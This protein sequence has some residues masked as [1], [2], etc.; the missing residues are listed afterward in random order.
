[1][2]SNL[3][4]QRACKAF[5]FVIVTLLWTML[6]LSIRPT[7]IVL[8]G[9]GPGGVGDTQGTSSLRLWLRADKGVYTDEACSTVILKNA[10]VAC[11]ADQSGN[12]SHVLQFNAMWQPTYRDSRA[13]NGYKP[14]LEFITDTLTTT[15]G[16]QLFS[17]PDSG[18]TMMVVFDSD[19]VEA[20][21]QLLGYG[22]AHTTAENHNLELGYDMGSVGLHRGDDN[23]TLT[24]GQVITNHTY[25]I[26]STLVLTSGN[27][28][29]NIRIFKNGT[30]Q[31]LA[32]EGSGWLSATHYPVTSV[33]LD[34]GARRDGN[35]PNYPD[36][37]PG[38]FHMGD[39]A[40]MIAYTTTLNTAQRTI[41]ENYLNAKYNR[42]VI[43]NDKYSGPYVKD[44]VGIG[45]EADGIHTA[46]SSA[47]LILEDAGY[48]EKN[49]DYIFAGHSADT[50]STTAANLPTGIA[51]RWTREWY[52]AKVYPIGEQRHGDV[53]LK[54]DFSE[55]GIAGTPNGL[56]VL[57][58]RNR[59]W[60]T[61]EVLQTTSY[62]VGDQ[63]IFVTPA[64]LDNGYYTL[65]K[66]AFSD[67]TVEDSQQPAGPVY[68]FEDISGGASVVFTDSDQ[69]TGSVSLGFTFNF[70]DVDYEEVYIGTD[71][72]ITFIP[73]Q[74]DD[75]TL[76]TLPNAGD[77]NGIIAG[78]WGDLDPY[79]PPLGNG[80]VYARME[81]SAPERYFI[82]QYEQVEYEDNTS[83]PYSVTFQI[84]LFESSNIIE[85][86]Y[87]NIDIRYQPLV[88]IENQA[89]TQ[90]LQYYYSKSPFIERAVRFARSP[91]ILDK[92]VTD[93]TPRVGD[94]ITYTLV[95]RSNLT[96]TTHTAALSETLDNGLTYFETV[97]Y[98]PAQSGAVATFAGQTLRIHSL[99]IA[100]GQRIT[101][102]IPVMVENTVLPAT[103]LMNTS[104]ITSVE[105][106][107]YTENAL[108]IVA[109]TCW[110]RVAG[111]AKIYDNVQDAIEA[112]SADDIVQIAGYCLDVETRGSAALTLQQVAYLTKSLTLRGGYTPDFSGEADPDTN[113]TIL[114]ARDLG[115]VVY[116][117][118]S[119]PP[120]T[121][122]VEGLQLEGGNAG[123][124]G[125]VLNGG[126]GVYALTST[127]TLSRTYISRSSAQQGG[128]MYA[129]NSILTLT[130]NH[131]FSNTAS[132]EGGGVYIVNASAV[133]LTGNLIMT[134]TASEEGGGGRLL[135][136]RG[137]ILNENYI[138]DNAADL[139]GGIYLE[140][141]AI[142]AIEDAVENNY[143][144]TSGGG[145]YMKVVTATVQGITVT[146]NQ[147]ID[148]G[149]GFYLSNSHAVAIA[150]ARIALNTAL[151]YGGGVYL[152]QSDAG[153]SNT[154][155]LTNVAMR[156]GGVYFEDSDAHL[157]NN[158]I[159]ANT[160]T[161][162]DGGGVYVFSS[163]CTLMTN[164]LNSNVTPGYGGALYVTNSDGMIA[165]RNTIMFNTGY[166]GGGVAVMNSQATFTGNV[167]FSNTAS[168]QGG[169]IYVDK[170]APQ[171]I[172]ND[173]TLNAVSGTRSTTGGGGFYLRDTSA[174][175]TTN[176]IATNTV[177]IQGGGLFVFGTGGTPNLIS[178]TIRANT[179]GLRGGGVY[180]NASNAH[181]I[182]NTIAENIAEGTSTVW[183]LGGGVCIDGSNPQ[184]TG[185]QIRENI[186]GKR[187]G[188]IFTQN[189][190]AQITGN[191]IIGNSTLR[192]RG[193]GVYIYSGNPTLTDNLIKGNL[194]VDASY[195]EGGGIYVNNNNATIN[196]NTFKDNFANNNGGGMY[197]IYSNNHPPLN[198]NVFL[199][200]KATN[201]GGGIYLDRHNGTLRN[202]VVAG[203]SI[204]NGMGS[205]LYIA[206]AS[207]KLLHTT[208]AQNSGGDQTG[209]SIAEFGGTLSTVFLTNT[210]IADQPVGVFVNSG[211]TAHL[212]GT[213]WWQ[214]TQDT[215][216]MGHI[217]THTV[218]VYA[219]PDFIAP[220]AGDY[221]IGVNSFALDAG[222]DGGVTTDLDGESRPHF[223]GY[224]IG[225]D[226]YAGTC[227]VRLN[228]APLR[229]A[230]IQEAVD[231]ASAGDTVKVAGT[232]RGVESHAG[233]S[234][235]VYLNKSITIQGGYAL[236]NWD[237]PDPVVY[238]T[239]VDAA[240]QGRV[241]YI[242]GAVQ[243]TLAGMR[244]IGGDASAAGDTRGGGLYVTTAQVTLRAVEVMSNTAQDGG[245]LYVQGGAAQLVNTLIAHNDADQHGSGIYFQGATHDLKHLTLA[246]NT[247]SEGVYLAG[248]STARFTNT[249]LVSHTLGINVTAGSTADMVA[250]LWGSGDWANQT[251]WTAAGTFN[252]E[253]DI[254]ADPAFVAPDAGD[255]HI[256][257][258]SGARDRG[259]DAGVTTDID[260]EA[261]DLNPD[262][263]IDEYRTCWIRLND[264][265]IT[266]YADIQ[267]AIDASTAPDDVIKVAGYCAGVNQRPRQDIITSGTVTQ[268]I[269]L[270]K[271]LTIQ[272]GYTMTNW[273]TP[274]PRNYP[275]TIDAV[276]QGRVLYIT[277]NLAGDIR[278]TLMNLRLVNGE[279]TGL[280]GSGSGD[281]G[282]GLYS[283]SANPIISSCQVLSN[284]GDYG[285][286][287]YIV[288][289]G[290]Q[291]YNTII[292][293]NE[294]TQQGGAIQGESAALHFIYTTFANNTG[295][296]GLYL[297]TNSTALLTNTILAGHTVG[298]QTA[299]GSSAALDGVLWW[300]NGT[301]WSGSVTR[302]HERVGDPAF[303]SPASQDYHILARSAAID[304]V[305]NAAG[306]AADVDLEPRPV[307]DGYDLGADEFSV[308]VRVSKTAAPDPVLAGDTLMFTIMVTNT[309]NVAFDAVITDTLPDH[310]TPGGE[311]V[312]T[313]SIPA[314]GGVWSQS[315]NVTVSPSYVGPITNTGVVTTIVKG[316]A[317]ESTL[318]GPTRYFTRAVGVRLGADL[319]ISKVT[320]ADTATPGDWV[321]YTLTYENLGPSVV[322]DVIISDLVPVSLISVTYTSSGAI[323]TSTGGTSYT[324]AVAPLSPGNGGTITV[325]GT[326]DSGYAGGYAFTNTAHI[327]NTTEVGDP[328]ANNTSM[329]V[330]IIV[331]NVAPIAG[332][333]TAITDEDIPVIIP[334]RENDEDLNGDALSV[335]DVGS[336]ITG[337]T[338][339]N[340]ATITYIPAQDFFGTDIF[341]YTVSDGSL[342][343]VGA[344]TVTVNSVNDPP[345]GVSD[346]VT[347]DE[348]TPIV[349]DVLAND[350]DVD[351]DS[352]MIGSVGIPG[353]GNVT[354]DG[355]ML[356]YTPTL[357]FNGVDVF[358]YT[359][360][361]GVFAD[362]ATVMMTINAVNDAPV[363]HDDTANTP[364]NTPRTVVV[365][366][367]DTDVEEDP[368]TVVAVGNPAD[369]AAT[370]NGT[371]V[372]Y[373]PT[374]S[375][376][377]YEV[378]TYTISD[379][380]LEATGTITI[381]VG[382]ANHAPIAIDDTAITV[383][384]TSVAVKPLSNDTDPDGDTLAVDAIIQP[385]HGSAVYSA[386]R[387]VY[388]P[389]PDF[390]GSDV[391][392]YT[393]SDGQLTDMA[394]I[395]ITVTPVN[396]RP[397]AVHDDF[398]VTEDTPISL[399]VL[400]NDRD[401][402]VE[403]ILGISAV[404]IPLHGNIHISGTTALIYTPT[405]NYN[406]IDV[407]TYTVSD[408]VLA[409]DGPL[410]DTAIVT[411]TITPVND[412]PVATDVTVNTDEKTV[413]TGMLFVIDPDVGD[414][415]SYSLGA[416]P[417]Y[418]SAAVTT[419]TGVWH[420]IPADLSADYT[421]TF[422]IH[423]TDGALMDTATITVNVTAV[424]DPPQPTPDTV[425]INEDQSIAIFPLNNDHD[426]GLDAGGSLFLTAVGLPQHGAVTYI[427]TSATLFY[428]PSTNFNG[429]DTF[430]YTVSDGQLMAHSAVNIT[431]LAVNDAPSF[432][433][434]IDPVVVAEDVGVQTLSW[435]SAISPGPADETEQGLDFTLVND[436]PTFFTVQPDLQETSGE[437]TFTPAPDVYGSVQVTATLQDNGGTAN[438]GVD[439]FTMTFTIE[440][441][442]V[443]D[444][445]YDINL[446]NAEIAE[447]LPISTTVGTF[448]SSDVDIDDVY[449][450]TLV[451]GSGDSDNGD[452]AI[453]GDVLK[454]RS[455]FDYETRN[456]YSIRVRSMDSGGSSFE[457]VC[458]ILIT[459]S[460]EAPFF[461]SMPVTT[462]MEDTVYTYTI[463]ADDV[464]AGD[465]LTITAPTLP[466]W[467][468]L[469]G[470]RSGA[471][472]SGT[473]TFT[474]MGEHPIVLQVQ[475]TGGLIT[476]QSFTVTVTFT[477][478]D[479]LATYPISEAMDVTIGTSVMITFSKVINTSTLTFSVIPDPG[480]WQF[481]WSA[482]D[483]VVTL[484]HN[485]FASD[486]RY[487]FTVTAASDLAGNPLSHPYV[488]SFTTEITGYSIY[489]PTVVRNTY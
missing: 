335:M 101:L 169:G 92:T 222:V 398:T 197:I 213:L 407:F 281:A 265:A 214:N 354:A 290:V 203:N 447:D 396:D 243:P 320:M 412:P 427:S 328:P 240:G 85:I 206:G 180:L 49:G 345:L 212:E 152:D 80:N 463:T 469:T 139:G 266:E 178:N 276:G 482:G 455:T 201:N 384:D 414:T 406:G 66:V 112:A 17:A 56:Y 411:L 442:P 401:V 321:T 248:N 274:D 405:L 362:T 284:A 476:S 460:N 451:S 430:T 106:P 55:G 310:V 23:A 301:N 346:S 45:K 249:I 480:G 239:I 210:I 344:V 466:T 5:V 387:V 108:A 418:G 300:A 148:D 390:N 205:G 314:S 208:V 67:Y 307:G 94:K 96:E 76:Q 352:L 347:T 279:A 408:N 394:L 43:S 349:F 184:L 261:R 227:F 182:A 419:T 295:N 79:D 316:T 2:K 221:H 105:A 487:T 137:M 86:H 340:G 358:T 121:A 294:A 437:L 27:A 50:N 280:S 95:L 193:G 140:D 64:L 20:R 253:S 209:I 473:P 350:I 303:V 383:E 277:G 485:D 10:P 40:E 364:V 35:D 47:G 305:V 244:L 13:G 434:G 219:D 122:T 12:G 486:T 22:S 42:I 471:T 470:N 256:E 268:A 444:P 133:T 207:P 46:S 149:A 123:L 393:V 368:L 336:P 172:D 472:L 318:I 425:E 241:F 348:D 191:T 478:L 392:T 119:D 107:K 97:L 308:G 125:G 237:Y 151:K 39:I 51:S 226:E 255:Y 37:A 355:N 329:P 103:Q 19:D 161:S 225:A 233:M 153:L 247:G 21:K 127:L 289:G 356:T 343:D 251:N 333:D 224:D 136:S 217:Y 114:D 194:S 220:T 454:T 181:L 373:T 371:T 282:G 445:P 54:F 196:Q 132:E 448:T 179:S 377:G 489:L 458:M 326:L 353:H 388:T 170:N 359:V 285:G 357:D 465:V 167:V 389:N 69:I 293:G 157:E 165:E 459:D 275:T 263:G 88:G 202:L 432:T 143:A 230:T 367:N 111:A 404:S 130:D 246:R 258:T 426:D 339:T 309:G 306:I 273:T 231:A 160:A 440:I 272:G 443:N 61:F 421:V 52:I 150:D 372:T 382:A 331:L 259:V 250:T 78:W 31:T 113:A 234:Q 312:W 428:T 317:T 145:V 380:G 278:P 324:W 183:A 83:T 71:G 77:P 360:S 118:G 296:T 126:G 254:D 34:I 402:D 481:V 267:T 242:T 36:I 381:H 366:G 399:D 142:V 446:S 162:G 15:H 188:G 159:V 298:V 177:N 216:G 110:A 453:V 63:V 25:T 449:T 484:Q 33:P 156:G 116:I 379:S 342:T 439:T 375:F 341:T 81:G 1:M 129:D 304:A 146:H 58:W 115:R 395:Y 192:G 4:Y 351:G 65:G 174:Q 16:V 120:V 474:E 334:V 292:A 18:F 374:P 332:D 270:S 433:P 74:P 104:Q 32:L 186:S 311:M 131:I 435:A 163:M 173:V 462:A 90:G 3:L 363:A 286:G 488:W 288:D 11:W 416:A 134:N 57:L 385:A 204:T 238:P 218:N 68:G 283:I 323:V 228:N 102:T 413:I 200:N 223:L 378:F 30:A 144:S 271:T 8:A 330:T 189:S 461:T 365:L 109:D 26:L 117:S 93:S 44:L 475:D 38:E 409:P 229:Y 232:C 479:I 287:I 190:G 376:T 158:E 75:S 59:T 28:P 236:T 464:D 70:Y 257:V 386:N 429:I 7:K 199:N 124:G 100:A 185:N 245:G 424:N 198:G 195:G 369:G 438:G 299:G 417:S 141:C 41:V 337:S 166:I 91:L 87:K 135:H 154:Q 467:L 211:S 98:D 24:S 235:T 313:A 252:S 370:T 431:V 72:F 6:S 415:L 89:G 452:F 147:A 128:G 53:V 322:S 457:K 62:I 176:T 456:S 400:A 441:S 410:T 215:G 262:L 84:K 73:D 319:S 468:S 14:A 361:D 99:E 171:F 422:T 338:T 155:V 138:F 403:D 269:Y 315:F 420:Y 436:S 48:L 264:D 260:G 164:T 168:F 9:S 397:V 291:L 423:V 60:D 450:Y 325:I 391:I 483:R 327:T 29:D 187:G 82:V 302:N 477:P 175:L 297:N